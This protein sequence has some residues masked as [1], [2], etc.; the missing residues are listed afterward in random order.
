[1]FATLIDTYNLWNK[2]TEK[3]NDPEIKCFGTFKQAQDLAKTECLDAEHA[4]AIQIVEEYEHK[5]PNQIEAIK[6]ALVTDSTDAQ[7]TLTTAH[8]SKGLEW[9]QVKIGDDFPKLFKNKNETIQ[10]GNKEDQLDQQEINLI[11]VAITRAR[12]RIELNYE[13]QKLL[14]FKNK[15][16]Q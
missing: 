11:Y 1:M 16:A 8:K 15:K 2:K 9:N 7:L 14:N 4:M 3:I 5:I 10:I 13:I 12:K 6:N